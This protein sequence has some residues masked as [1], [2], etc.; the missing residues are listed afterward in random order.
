MKILVLGVS[1][2]VGNAYAEAAVRR[3]HEVIGLQHRTPPSVHGIARVIGQD[4]TD[5]DAL[6][7]TCL[8]LWPDVIVN[9]AAISSPAAV[10]SDPKTAEKVNVALPRKLA[11]ISS[12][13][14]ARLLHLST[15]MVFDGNDNEPRRSTDL[16]CP[17]N[18]YGQ[19]KL[20]AEREV[21]EHNTEDPVVLRITIVSGNSPGGERSIHE[22]LLQAIAR[23]ERPR[24]FEDEIRQPCSASN[25][26]DLLVELSERRDLHGIFHWAGSEALSR[27]EIGERILDRFGLPLK[28]IERV[29]KADDPAHAGRASKLCFNLH[30]LVGKVKTRPADLETLIEELELPENLTDWHRGARGAD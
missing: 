14:G 2:L 11:Q 17:T 7:R 22:K 18:L 6:T 19:M 4:A 3:R 13:I 27:Y 12:H 10:E 15:D 23:G 20:M 25:V 16:P 5:F 28:L 29:R 26:A 30:P 9:A 21:L 8:D 24:L 1:G